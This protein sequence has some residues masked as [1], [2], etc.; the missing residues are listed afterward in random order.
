MSKRAAKKPGPK[1]RKLPPD[2]TPSMPKIKALPA[3]LTGLLSREG[4]FA[5]WLRTKKLQALA[6]LIADTH[7]AFAGR[8]LNTMMADELAALRSGWGFEGYGALEVA[9]MA[10]AEMNR[11]HQEK[12]TGLFSLASS[13]AGSPPAP[14][15]AEQRS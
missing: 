6:T 15:T 5:A 8:G 13:L 14:P 7:E 2:R 9:H 12:M 1:T 11:R 4:E 3:S 10:A